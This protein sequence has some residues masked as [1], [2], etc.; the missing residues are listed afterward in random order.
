VAAAGLVPLMLVSS[1]EPPLLR[2]LGTSSQKPENWGVDFCWFLSDTRSW[3]G[4][5]RKEVSDFIKSV[6]DGRLGKELVQGQELTWR[7]LLIEGP[8]P[9]LMNDHLVVDRWTKISMAEWLGVL[10]KC[11]SE[12]WFLLFTTD[13]QQTASYVLMFQAWTKRT[14]HSS[15]TGR[16]GP[17]VNQWGRKESRDFQRHLLMGLERVGHKEADRI[18]DK[19]G[20]VPWEWTVT[21]KELMEV[22]GIGKVKAKR[23]MEAFGEMTETTSG[24]PSN[25]S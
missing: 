23:L 12:G 16:P 19:F 1:T 17:P 6:R 18:L 5:Q 20:R 25:G 14:E 2:A 13:I 4:V 24:P 15:L 9:R 7:L 10:W 8:A 11:Q 3:A 22:P 21:M